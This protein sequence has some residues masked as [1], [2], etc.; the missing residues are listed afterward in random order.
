MLFQS[1]GSY[2]KVAFHQPFLARGRR[3]AKLG[4]LDEAEGDFNKAVELSPNDADVLAAR[5]VFLADA[6]QPDRAAEGFNAALSLLD[7]AGPKQRFR[8]GVPIDF[9]IVQRDEVFERLAALRPQDARTRMARM[10][11][12]M[13]QG[14]F[15]GMRRDGERLKSTSTEHGAWAGAAA[16]C[17]GDREE[18]DRIRATAPR[19]S[20]PV[21]TIRLLGLAPTEE[22]LTTEL[23]QIAERMWREQPQ[24]RSYRRYLGLAQLR[25]AKY[26][27]AVASLE[28]SLA[29]GQQWQLDG[30]HWP[31]LAIAHHHLGNAE[32]ARRWLDKTAVWLELRNAAESRRAGAATGIGDIPPAQYLYAMAFY[33]EARALIDGPEAEPQTE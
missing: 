12:R 8:W 27:E 23:L 9:E 21:P 28:A 24:T 17:R 13:Q 6:G 18:Y 16:L 30:V 29:P 5:A 15:D 32:V 4:R 26:S 20:N 33:L 1:R 10:V 22:P 19:D 3:L 14:D 2:G 31:L 11:L 7:D 25:A